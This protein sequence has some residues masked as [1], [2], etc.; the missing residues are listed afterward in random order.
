MTPQPA[1][2]TI[3]TNVPGPQQQLYI[4]SHPMRKML[5]YV[6]L[7]MNQLVTIAIMSYNGELC[8]GITADYDQVPDVQAVAQGIERGLADLAAAAAERGA[9]SS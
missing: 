6:P 9:G 5:P 8:C 3:T 7:G 2:S 1:V 4:L